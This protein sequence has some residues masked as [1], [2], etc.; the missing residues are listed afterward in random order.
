MRSKTAIAIDWLLKKFPEIQNK[1]Y[2]STWA[3]DDIINFYDKVKILYEVSENILT[4]W[5]SNNKNMYRKE[6]ANLAE[7]RKAIF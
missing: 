5:H 2:F 1:E 3:N 7:I 4:K 6:P